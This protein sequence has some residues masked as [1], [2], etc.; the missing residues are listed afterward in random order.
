MNMKLAD[1]H[2]YIEKNFYIPE[3]YQQIYY[4]GNQLINP[5]LRLGKLPMMYKKE[6]NGIINLVLRRNQLESNK[7]LSFSVVL[8]HRCK[9]GIEKTRFGVVL[10]ENATF[11]NLS[12]YMEE[13]WK[14]EQ[15]CLLYLLYQNFYSY[16]SLRP[17]SQVLGKNTHIYLAILDISSSSSSSSSSS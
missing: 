3:A 17:I 1:L 10:P 16:N 14:M 11:S 5:L 6:P 2:N 12:Q 9:Y 13:T 7:V 15:R 4:E 8:A